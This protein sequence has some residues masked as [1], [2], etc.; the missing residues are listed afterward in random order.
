MTYFTSNEGIC[1]KFRGNFQ[2]LFTRE[3]ALTSAQFDAYLADFCRLEATKAAECEAD[4][5]NCRNEQDAW[6]RWFP[7]RS[8]PEAFAHIR[9][10][11]GDCL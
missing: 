5:E 3:L 11:A 1:W 7:L 2:K 6:N 9:F 4:T 10:L 8:V